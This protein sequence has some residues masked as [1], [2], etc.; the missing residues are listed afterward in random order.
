MS[1]REQR[2]AA[3]RNSELSTGP[4]TPEGKSHSRFNAM[5]HGLCS[6][7]ALLPG[8]DAEALAQTSP[9][10]STNPPDPSTSRSSTVWS[11]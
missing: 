8:E 4:I 9:A 2:R 7:Q 5:R 10:N 3:R 11:E 6:Q 1:T